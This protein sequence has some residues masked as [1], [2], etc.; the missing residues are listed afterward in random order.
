MFKICL[1]IKNC[2]LFLFLYFKLQYFLEQLFTYRHF[3]KSVKKKN[4]FDR[5]HL[6]KERFTWLFG[7]LNL[8]RVIQTTCII[9]FPNL[10]VCLRDLQWFLNFNHQFL[11]LLF[12]MS[13]ANDTLA[14]EAQDTIDTS[15][16]IEWIEEAID[17]GH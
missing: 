17:E 1:M 2:N 13:N 14:A 11:L 3:G 6:K 12:I 5:N 8:H 10:N 15:K 16:L 9:L 7:S 4:N